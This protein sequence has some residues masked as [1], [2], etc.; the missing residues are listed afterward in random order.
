MSCKLLSYE[1]VDDKFIFCLEC[2]C[3]CVLKLCVCVLSRFADIF[4][5]ALLKVLG[6]RDQDFFYP[7]SVSLSLSSGH[8]G[9]FALL[10][11]FFV[12]IN[13]MLPF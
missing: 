13:V 9:F 4:I 2:V 11:T 12:L 7:S 3:V 8:G 6:L 5:I 10:G 1:N